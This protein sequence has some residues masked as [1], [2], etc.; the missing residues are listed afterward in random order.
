MQISTNQSIRR[1]SPTLRSVVGSGQ[2]HGRVRSGPDQARSGQVRSILGQ[3]RSRPGQVRSRKSADFSALHGWPLPNI[4]V[5]INCEYYILLIILSSRLGFGLFPM[6]RGPP[7]RLCC[8]PSIFLLCVLCS[9][10]CSLLLS[11]RFGPIVSLTL[12]DSR[13][14]FGRGLVHTTLGHP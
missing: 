7:A 14:W 10:V 9:I 2:D 8:P 1:I 11:F 6:E 5:L 4:V 12:W 13:P 3:V